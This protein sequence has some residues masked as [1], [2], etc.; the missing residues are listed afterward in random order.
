MDHKPEVARRAI[1]LVEERLPITVDCSDGSF[2]DWRVAGPALVTSATA[3][4]RSIFSLEPWPTNVAAVNHLTRV[5]TEQVVTFAWLA[6]DPTG[7][8]PVWAAE[9]GLRRTKL[10]NRIESLRAEASYRAVIDAEFPE[11][12]LTEGRLTQYAELAEAAGPL[13]DLFV[14]CKQAD[15]A[16]RA[17]FDGLDSHPLAH[18]YNVVYSHLSAGMHAGVQST[19]PYVQHDAGTT[20]TTIGGPFHSEGEEGTWGLATIIYCLM[21]L[22]SSEA[23][24]WPEASDVHAVIAA[25]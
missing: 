2:A 12:L 7:R 10:H 9:L 6:D 22:V 25:G 15:S 16:W 21:L 1:A 8:L 11:G 18:V 24:G 3:T 19:F 20:H 17:S 4:L 13:P 5:L 23:L 14:R